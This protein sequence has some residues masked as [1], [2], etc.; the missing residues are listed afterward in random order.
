MGR[1]THPEALEPGDQFRTTASIEYSEADA[2]RKLVVES[3]LGADSLHRYRSQP[4]FV[5]CRVRAAG[6]E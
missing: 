3:D 2:G 5:S 1:L 6:R 4:E